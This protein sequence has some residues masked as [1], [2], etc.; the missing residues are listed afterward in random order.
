MGYGRAVLLYPISQTQERVYRILYLCTSYRHMYVHTTYCILH[1]KYYVCTKYIHISNNYPCACCTSYI[2]L[3]LCCMLYQE[4]VSMYVHIQ[5]VLRTS[6]KSMYVHRYI[7]TYT[8]VRSTSYICMCVCIYTYVH[9]YV[10]KYVCMYI[11]R[12]FVV[13][14][15]KGRVNS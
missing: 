11:C 9:M 6:Y 4:V 15:S 14:T 7:C 12:Y 8:Y 2:L 5:Y 13:I 1:T 10:L 3:I